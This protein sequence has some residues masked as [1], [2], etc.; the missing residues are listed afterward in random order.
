MRFEEKAT[1][2]VLVVLGGLAMLCGVALCGI[3]LMVGF[4]LLTRPTSSVGADAQPG[5]ALLVGILFA[6]GVIAAGWAMVRKGR[7]LARSRR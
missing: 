7:Y 3:Q 1:S 6:S 2:V 5:L 4:S